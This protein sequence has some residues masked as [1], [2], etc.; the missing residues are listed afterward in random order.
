MDRYGGVSSAFLVVALTLVAIAIAIQLAV[1]TGLTIGFWG[2][3]AAAITLGVIWGY[4]RYAALVQGSGELP[5]FGRLTKA[6]RSLLAAAS[7]EHVAAIAAV[8]ISDML[9]TERAAYVPVRD[10]RLIIGRGTGSL[11]IDPGHERGFIRDVAISREA[12]NVVTSGGAA[13][14][15]VALLGVPVTVG[16]AVAG[17]LVAVRDRDRPFTLTE[18]H[19]LAQ[20][21]PAVAAALEL[22]RSM[23]T[24]GDASSRDPV[25]GLASRVQFDRD[26][27][28]IAKER[29]QS[30]SAVAL[31]DVDHFRR[32][33]ERH[34][35]LVGDQVL[36]SVADVLRSQVRDHDTIYRF[37]GDEFCLMLR[38]IRSDQAVNVLD[39]IRRAVQHI[40]IPSDDAV[41]DTKVTVSIGVAFVYPSDPARAMRAADDALHD[42]K[43]SGRDR[44]VL[45]TDSPFDRLPAATG[46]A[47][48]QQRDA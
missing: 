3:L 33:I 39:R 36:E 13:G 21:S 8:E 18:Q 24:L 5:V 17:V 32:M 40:V 1:T 41:G 48:A 34:G 11:V 42:A 46:P 14:R 7:E 10:G 29:R 47:R 19:V 23:R 2:L 38:D 15:S 43:T 37:D 27:G 44:V 6:G 20:L 9:E 45:G 25:T 12:V 22:V 4:R 30:T 35:H 16:T 28:R 31:V 26:L